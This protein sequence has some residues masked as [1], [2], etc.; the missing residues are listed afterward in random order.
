MVRPRQRLEV[1]QD[2]EANGNRKT[3]RHG[4][5]KG[6]TNAKA[7]RNYREVMLRAR[8]PRAGAPEEES[9]REEYASV[10]ERLRP[11]DMKRHSKY[12]AHIC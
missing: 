2:Q 3:R 4:L 11:G 5:R 9:W 12:A 1:T 8:S 6:W 7:A 10:L